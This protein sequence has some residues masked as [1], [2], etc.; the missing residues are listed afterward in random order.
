[1]DATCGRFRRIN[2]RWPN[3]IVERVTEVDAQWA[4]HPIPVYAATLVAPVNTVPYNHP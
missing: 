4:A 2:V 1:M 3:V